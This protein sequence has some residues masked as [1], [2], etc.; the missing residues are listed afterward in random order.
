MA[1]IIRGPDWSPPFHISTDVSDTTI[2]GVLGQ[3]EGQETYAIYFIS[4]NL[5]PTELNY[6]ITENEF[7]V[8]VHSINKFLHYITGYEVFVHTDHSAIRFLINKPITNSRVTRWILLFQEFNITIIDRPGKENIVAD[9]LSCIQHEDGT[10]PVDDIFPNEHLFV[11]SIKTPWF[12]DIANYLATRK[13]PNHLSPPEK[14]RIIV[15]SSNYS[16]VDN[17]LFRTGPDII[18]IRCVR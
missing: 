18:I 5:T 11:V 8:V 3:K 17:Y 6:T 16:W 1:P 13:L 9:F 7:L 2:G 15:H 12:A 10:K 14:S 4:K